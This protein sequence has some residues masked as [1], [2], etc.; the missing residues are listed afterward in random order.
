MYDKTLNL[1]PPPFLIWEHC[2]CWLDNYLEIGSEKW[3]FLWDM[4]EDT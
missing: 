2:V 4:K 3:Y 1:P